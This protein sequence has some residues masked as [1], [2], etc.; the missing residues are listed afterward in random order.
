MT[1]KTKII[2][3]L[4]IVAVLVI[5]GSILYSKMTAE[6]PQDGVNARL[7]VYDNIRGIR[8]CEIFLIG[9][10]AIT[11]NLDFAVYNTIGLNYDVSGDSLNSC[12]SEIS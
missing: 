1:T 9:G 7:I 4:S 12:P 8:F 5:V 11:G 10:N 3:T 6:V 2:I